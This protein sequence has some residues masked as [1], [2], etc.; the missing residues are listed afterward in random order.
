MNKIHIFN[1]SHYLTFVV[2]ISLKQ[3]NISQRVYQ[4]SSVF[5]SVFPVV[6]WEQRKYW[7]STSS[8]NI[9]SSVSL[10]CNFI[11]QWFWTKG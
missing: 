10:R 7:A 3:T 8:F 5:I 2:A 6:E 9:N 11:F 1:K 4:R